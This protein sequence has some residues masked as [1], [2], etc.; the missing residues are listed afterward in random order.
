MFLVLLG[1]CGWYSWQLV[2]EVQMWSVAMAGLWRSASPGLMA[3]SERRVL[4][5]SRMLSNLLQPVAGDRVHN[6]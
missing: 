6:V 3:W 1:T 2:P 5:K 4:V